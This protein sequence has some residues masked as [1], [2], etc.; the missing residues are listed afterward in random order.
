MKSAMHCPALT[1]SMSSRLAQHLLTQ[2][3][4]LV[5]QAWKEKEQSTKK[6]EKR[7]IPN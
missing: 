7:Q 1:T 6:K 3:S 4:K 2:Q 5:G